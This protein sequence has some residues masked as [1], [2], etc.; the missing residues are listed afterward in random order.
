MGAPTRLPDWLRHVVCISTSRADAGIY[1]PLVRA[2]GGLTDMRVTCLA[3][4]T[5]AE[6]RFGSPSKCPT[7]WPGATVRFVNHHAPGDS[8][9]SVAGSAG[10]AVAEFAK[11]LD[12]DRPDLVFVL[13]DRTEMLS[14]ALATLIQRIP[15]AHLHGG[16]TT[17]GAYDDACRHAVT[18]LSHVHFPALSRHGDVIRQMGEE[19]WRIFVVGALAMDELA[20]FSPDPIDD[21]SA[22]V[23]LDLRR[24]TVMV[25]Y[26]PE[27]LGDRPAA[28]Q[29]RE[30]LDG[31]GGLDVSLLL[32]GTNADVGHE[33][34]FAA[35]QRLARDRT[36][37]VYHANLSQDEFWNCLA[38]GCTLAGNSSAG[39]IEAATLR[40]PVVNIGA[41]Q[42]G[43]LRARNVIDVP[44]SVSEIAR[45]VRRS[46]TGE[47]R[48]SLCDLDNPYGDG[49]SANRILDAL[50]GLPPPDRLC[51]KRWSPIRAD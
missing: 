1:R 40:A 50:S 43:R 16:D 29:I 35:L 46:L 41:R 27:T 5:H 9:V 42:A 17:T 30:V 36:G 31:L 28:A 33:S 6:D 19:P 47:F 49:R 15:I 44:C 13:G 45:A 14:A 32:L 51:M 34:I 24:P 38:H 18:K 20:G 7:V 4:G 23:G 22:R 26:H 8:P 3:G 25:L 11:A 37:A 39:I 2:L 48:E 21:V 10:R 12:A